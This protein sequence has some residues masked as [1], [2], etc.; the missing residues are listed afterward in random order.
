M[1]VSAYANTLK[2]R[3]RAE[4]GGMHR[5]HELELK[6][7]MLRLLLRELNWWVGSG[8][9]NWR[10]RFGERGGRF[11][12]GVLVWRT[13]LESWIG[14]LI[15]GKLVWRARS[16][17]L[18]GGF[19]PVQLNWGFGLNWS[20]S[21]EGPE[22]E[23]NWTGEGPES[24]L[25]WTDPEICTDLERFRRGFGELIWRDGTRKLNRIWTWFGELI[26]GVETRELGW[27]FGLNWR[28]SGEGPVRELNW[29]GEGLGGELGRTVP[30]IWTELELSWR[31][32]G[33]LNRRDGA[34]E[35]NRIWAGSGELICGVGTGKLSW[36]L[37][38][39]WSLSG[40]GPG[41]ELSWTGEGL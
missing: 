9:L 30:E 26:C 35:L 12:H 32:S 8:E 24:E 22:R 33:D 13:D 21:R 20:L 40:K 39:N 19:E 25:N 7:P 41:R 38:L 28:F 18:I 34:G 23:L 3:G 27:R 36:R 37:G 17:E 6:L 29:T 4:Q 2:Y 10:V 11:V 31:G 14:E 1:S 15:V 5:V 16:G